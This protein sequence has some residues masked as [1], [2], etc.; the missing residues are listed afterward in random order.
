MRAF[1]KTATAA[2]RRRINDAA[3]DAHRTAHR[4]LTGTHCV[5]GCGLLLDGQ[6]LHATCVIAAAAVYHWLGGTG[7]GT[8]R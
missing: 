4:I 2:I 5:L 1:L 8:A 7:G 3:A 6:W